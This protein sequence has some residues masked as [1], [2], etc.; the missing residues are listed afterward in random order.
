MKT[1]AEELKELNEHGNKMTEEINRLL[2]VIKN[3][4]D[5]NKAKALMSK[6]DELFTSFDQKMK[7]FD[8]KHGDE[9][10]RLVKYLDDKKRSRN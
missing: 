10:K 7:D 3:T 5:T 4:P 6:A 9:L 2:F 1:F 8:S